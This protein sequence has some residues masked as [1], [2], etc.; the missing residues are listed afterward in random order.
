MAFKMP[1][2]LKSP[3]FQAGFV[4]NI[5]T[6]FDKM[7]EN[8]E[9]YKLAA[10][11]RG[12][13]L[14]NELT[15]TKDRLKLEN[16]RKI[17]I[18]GT[19]GAPM[20]E[21]LD[22][23]NLLT[24]MAGESTGDFLDRVES[25]VGKVQDAGGVPESFVPNENPYY[26]EQ[27][28]EE[29]ETKYN[30][31]KEHL[32]KNNSVFGDS[33]ELLMES[34]KPELATREQFGVREKESL[35]SVNRQIPGGKEITDTD[36]INM[37]KIVDQNGAWPNKGFTKNLDGTMSAILDD[38]IQNQVATA[39]VI[40]NMHYKYTSGNIA[41]AAAQGVIMTKN[42]ASFA[43]KAEDFQSM[44]ADIKGIEIYLA[45]NLQGSMANPNEYANTYAYAVDLYFYVV[46]Q[47]AKPQDRK[48]TQENINQ[49]RRQILDETGISVPNI[50]G[51][52]KY[53]GIG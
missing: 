30:S 44:N 18:A 13:E 38:N 51:I 42:I 31:W 27:R 49:L 23:N 7:A 14:R 17:N 10:M 22:S 45:Q 9:K 48:K 4:R 32:D 15:A 8:A 34:Q 43:D 24:M 47:K 50:F 2:L 1:G 16:Q 46:S 19:Y 25:E 29:Y 36:L 20:A 11:S 33:Y 6:R 53:Q 21:W 39:K 26:G 35:P 41:D 28:Y 12:Q 3:A 40:S 52:E 5:N 37:N